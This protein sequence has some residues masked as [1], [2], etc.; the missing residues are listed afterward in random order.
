MEDGGPAFGSSTGPPGDSDASSNFASTVLE[1]S[2]SETEDN[3]K[4]GGK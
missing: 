3:R 2:K 1:K 4:Y